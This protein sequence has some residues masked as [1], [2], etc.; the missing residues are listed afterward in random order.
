MNTPNEVLLPPEQQKLLELTK[1]AHT[2]G[3]E[4][5][6]EI[7]KDHG[8]QIEGDVTNIMQFAAL[9]GFAALLGHV[10]ASMTLDTI[11]AGNQPEKDIMNGSVGALV[12]F[13]KT[14]QNVF[15]DT[16]LKFEKDVAEI[17]QI[18]ADFEKQYANE[19]A[20]TGN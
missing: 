12:M 19:Q 11:A 8:E 4:L 13:Q 16:L 5:L 14:I 17:D 9:D 20:R 1:R 18:V 15:T 6:G 7:M 3:L 10:L 2:E